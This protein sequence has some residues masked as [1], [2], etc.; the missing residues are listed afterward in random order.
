MPVI[1]RNV[2]ADYLAEL[3]RYYLALRHTVEGA[4]LSE[5]EAKRYQSPYERERDHS[6]PDLTR[7]NEDA[8]LDQIAHFKVSVDSLKRLPKKARKMYP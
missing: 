7:I 4:P 6:P 3:E 2:V 8:L 5:G 1:H